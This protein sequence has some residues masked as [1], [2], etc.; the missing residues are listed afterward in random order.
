MKFSNQATGIPLPALPHIVHIIHASYIISLIP[1]SA[2]VILVGFICHKWDIG[3]P[4]ASSRFTE[5]WT[6]NLLS[7][8]CFKS[9]NTSIIIDGIPAKGFGQ[10]TWNPCFSFSIHSFTVFLSLSLFGLWGWGYKHIYGTKSLFWFFWKQRPHIISTKN[11]VSA[12]PS[13]SLI[14]SLIV[15]LINF[16]VDDD[17]GDGDINRS[18]NE[19]W[20]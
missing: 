19:T 11:L 15:C 7:S 16:Y 17:K 14:L 9:R 18:D 20:S 2:L 3:C 6:H 12:L 1:R 8:K 5:I 10:Y 13:G 4:R